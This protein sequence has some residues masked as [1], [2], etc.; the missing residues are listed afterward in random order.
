MSAFRVRCLVL[1]M[2]FKH[3][4][5]FCPTAFESNTLTQKKYVKEK[6]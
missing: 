5:Q 1:Q 6:F 3:I 4:R 2:K